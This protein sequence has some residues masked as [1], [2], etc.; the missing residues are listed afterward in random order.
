MA[1]LNAIGQLFVK[2]TDVISLY[3][4]VL[5]IFIFFFFFFKL[6]IDALIDVDYHESGGKKFIK[7][8]TYMKVCIS[9][10]AGQTDIAVMKKTADVYGQIFYFFFSLF[11]ESLDCIRSFG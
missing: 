4:F 9:K 11:S 6:N 5:I 7:L 3:L 8:A 10:Q 2:F 1:G